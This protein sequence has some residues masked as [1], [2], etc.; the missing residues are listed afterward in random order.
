MKLKHLIIALLF[1]LFGNSCTDK[2]AGRDNEEVPEKDPVSGNIEHIAGDYISNGYLH[3]DKG[4][5]WMVASITPIKDKDAYILIRS[6]ADKKRPTCTFEGI[7]TL[8]DASKLAVDI[9]GRR[10]L[11]KFKENTMD[12]TT[13][14]EEDLDYLMYFCSGGGN[15]AGK[16]EKLNAPLDE[17]QLKPS[18]YNQSLSL[19][20]V[21][22]DIHASDQGSLNL[23]RIIPS[24]LEAD[25]RPVIHEIEGN[26]TNAEIEDLNSDGSPEVLVYITS[27]GSG[28]YGTII[29]YSVNNKKTLSQIYLPP[30]TDDRGLSRGYMGHDDFAIVET[31][32][33]RRFPI[34][35]EGD[36]NNNP[37]GGMRQIQYRL[38][39]GDNSRVFEVVDVYEYTPN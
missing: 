14:N 11:F 21:T 15:F 7:G 28:S 27:A 13:E 25:N 33:A 37:S 31:S 23:L 22:F 18:G 2:K 3:R 34:Y 12:I 8:L 39:D 35:K 29:G 16:Y 1:I 4:Y 26:V 19:Q 36:S 6:R 20:G 10:V 38:A 32:L 9:E 30:I 17:G 5:D 24:G